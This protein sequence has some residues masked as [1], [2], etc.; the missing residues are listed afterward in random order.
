[1]VGGA[2]YWQRERLVAQAQRSMRAG[3]RY[4]HLLAGTEPTEADRVR[5]NATLRMAQ[6][7]AR[8]MD[9]LS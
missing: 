1:M 9:G 7:W 3:T 8:M 5:H 4:E 2:A 6:R